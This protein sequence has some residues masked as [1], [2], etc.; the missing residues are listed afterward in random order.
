MP[1]ENRRKRMKNDMPGFHFVVEACQAQQADEKRDEAVTG[2]DS[3]PPSLAQR[4]QETLTH[5]LPPSA[6]CNTFCF[7]VETV[8][9]IEITPRSN[10]NPRCVPDI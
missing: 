6:R 1:D 4:L 7:R 9:D 2:E 3:G 8:P 5:P 10:G